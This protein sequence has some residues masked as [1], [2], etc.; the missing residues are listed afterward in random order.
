MPFAKGST[1]PRGSAFRQRQRQ[2]RDTMFFEAMEGCAGNSMLRVRDPFT[3]S[4]TV[5]TVTFGQLYDSLQDIPKRDVEG[6]VWSAVYDEVRSKLVAMDA[7][8]LGTST[9]AFD[10]HFGKEQLQFNYAFRQRGE[11]KINL[12]GK[13]FYLK[14]GC[15]AGKVSPELAQVV[16]KQ[17]DSRWAVKGVTSALLQAAGYNSDVKVMEECA[18]SLPSHLSVFS[19]HLGRSDVSVATVT[20]PAADPSLRKLPRSI[21]FQGLR[22][23]IS[24]TR[25]LGSKFGQR[26]A[27]AKAASASAKQS[28]KKVNRA[29]RKAQKQRAAADLAKEIEPGQPVRLLYPDPDDALPEASTDAAA[30]ACG[31]VVA[32]ASAALGHTVEESVNP[33]HARVAPTTGKRRDADVGSDSSD[34]ILA[35]PSDSL[36]L[37]PVTPDDAAGI[38]VRRSSRPH[39]KLRPY[40]EGSMAPLKG[41]RPGFFG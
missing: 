39:K 31:E 40:Y 1:R 35:S 14:V 13:V 41:L 8:R 22:V 9:A 38:G 23:S 25:S 33:S 16:V 2:R 12:A 24:V 37:V 34:S 19:E 17:L 7:Q 15:K 4:P 28:R 26:Q 27:Q 32:T 5:T 18:G 29:K 11:L 36:A 3:Y 21:M 6:L 10:L 30:A 20:A